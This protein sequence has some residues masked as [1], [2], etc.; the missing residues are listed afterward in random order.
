M[1]D[2]DHIAVYSNCGE[3]GIEIALMIDETIAAIGR[4]GRVTDADE[5]WRK[6]RPNGKR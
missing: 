2:Q 4:W 6:Q 3:P 1:D 5:V